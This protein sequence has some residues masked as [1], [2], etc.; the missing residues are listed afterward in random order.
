MRGTLL[1]VLLAPLALGACG[2]DERQGVAVTEGDPVATIV[3]PGPRPSAAFDTV[4]ADSGFYADPGLDSLT[5]DSLA[6]A[7]ETPA[8][9][10]PDFRAF[11]TTFRAA[12]REGEDAVAALARFGVDGLARTTVDAHVAALLEA[13]FRDRVLALTA[14][15]FRI[16]GDARD[17]TVTVG[18]DAD[19][20]IVPEDEAVTE[21]SL[22][23]RFEPRDGAYRLVGL[24]VTG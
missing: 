1:L 17:V 3:P 14:R 13:P 19:G 20:A 21:S 16:R 6:G 5:A 11:W 8:P 18:Y 12:V 7:S 23:L 4:Y 15:D 24:D 2:G 22:L 10:G 9:S